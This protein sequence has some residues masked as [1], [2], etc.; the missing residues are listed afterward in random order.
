MVKNM[1]KVG[2]I[3]VLVLTL[4]L[5]GCQKKN[6][7]E[8]EAAPHESTT[9]GIDDSEEMTEDADEDDIILFIDESADEI[10][11]EIDAEPDEKLTESV[12]G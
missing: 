9:V 12:F 5:C 10:V 3:A 2:I 11:G 4:A 8:K 6:E 1:K 7:T